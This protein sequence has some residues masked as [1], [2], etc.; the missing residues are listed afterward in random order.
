MNGYRYRVGLLAAAIPL[1]ITACSGSVKTKRVDGDWTGEFAGIPHYGRKHVQEVFETNAFFKDG[2]LVTRDCIKTLVQKDV[3]VP[4]MTA[5]FTTSYQPGLLENNEFG[6]D[7]NPDGTLKGVN[8]KSQPD[9]G[10]TLTALG[11]ALTQFA[12]ILSGQAFQ[13][14]AADPS[15]DVEP[16]RRDPNAGKFECNGEPKLV[17]R[18]EAGTALPADRNPYTNPAARAER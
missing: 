18:Y 2:K 5:K 9:R 10:A 13:T 6:I 3:M 14:T 7:L 11:G 8:S 12:P 16:D 17:G 15:R 1:A 4:D